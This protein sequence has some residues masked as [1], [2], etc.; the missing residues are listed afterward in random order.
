MK[1]VLLFA[2]IPFA[3][4]VGG[5]VARFILHEQPEKPFRLFA[6]IE[7]TFSLGVVATPFL[8]VAVGVGY[9]IFAALGIFG[10]D[11]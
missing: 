8:L 1:I 3:W 5:I 2:L 9:F 6:E 7:H 10:G 11:V 4:F